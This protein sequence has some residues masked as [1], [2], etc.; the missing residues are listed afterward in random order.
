MFED[1]RITIEKVK[2][3][4]Y[5]LQNEFNNELD[6]DYDYNGRELTEDDLN[7]LSFCID[8]FVEKAYLVIKDELEDWRK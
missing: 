4:L 6:Y 8:N 7:M 1:K 3:I 2:A 5:S